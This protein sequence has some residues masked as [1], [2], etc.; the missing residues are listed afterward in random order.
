MGVCHRWHSDELGPGGSQTRHMVPENVLFYSS[1]KGINRLNRACRG[2]H[3]M[4]AVQQKTAAGARQ[5]AIKSRCV[6]SK[7]G[8]A[9]R[10]QHTCAPPERCCSER[11]TG[12]TAQREGKQSTPGGR[13]AQR[14]PAP[15]PPQPSKATREETEGGRCS[16]SWQ[17]G[18]QCFGRCAELRRPSAAASRICRTRSPRPQRL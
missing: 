10:R 17:P 3:G 4:R 5:A 9:P 6:C 15:R 14:A 16:C 1:C 12:R 8:Q 13:E 2:S 7:I 18:S 11:M